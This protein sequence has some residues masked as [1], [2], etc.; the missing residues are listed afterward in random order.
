MKAQ[1]LLHIFGNIVNL[2]IFIDD[3]DKSTQGL[4]IS[5]RTAF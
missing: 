1:K 3:Q 2:S 5:W 4:K